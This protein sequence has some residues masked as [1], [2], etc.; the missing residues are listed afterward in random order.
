MSRGPDATKPRGRSIRP[1]SASTHRDATRRRGA[2]SAPGRSRSAA[3]YFRGP[4]ELRAW[5]TEHHATRDELLVGFHKRAT[6]VPSLTWPESVEEALCVGWIDGIRRS[7]DA[8]HYTIRFTPRRRGSIWSAKNIATV[9]ALIA[10]GRMRPAGLRAFEARDAARSAIYSHERDNA[11][12]LAAADERALRANVAAWR[13][14]SA[15][16]PHYRRSA[17][18]WVISAKRPETRASRL[19]ALIADSAAG[20]WVKPLRRAGS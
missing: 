19:A 9:H 12:T 20:R 4:A 16:P 10:S 18:H 6:G 2:A 3:I 11:A 14:F 15:Q 8:A 1:N 13:Y 7:V 5:L 17:Y